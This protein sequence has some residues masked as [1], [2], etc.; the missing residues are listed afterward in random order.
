MVIGTRS[1][2]CLF[3]PRCIPKAERLRVET[4]R[5]RCCSSD[6]QTTAAAWAVQHPRGVAVSPPSSISLV[7]FLGACALS[8]CEGRKSGPAQAALSLHVRRTYHHLPRARGG[9]CLEC[10]RVARPQHRQHQTAISAAVASSPWIRETWRSP[11]EARND[12][13]P[14][15]HPQQRGIPVFQ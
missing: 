10:V 9:T 12:S 2:G 6:S 15:V 13:R 11:A 14:G 4:E 3:L 1:R 5:D 8:L 7:V